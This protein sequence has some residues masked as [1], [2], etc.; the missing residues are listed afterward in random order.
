MRSRSEI[1]M[2]FADDKDEAEERR[3]FRKRLAEVTA[4]IKPWENRILGTTPPERDEKKAKKPDRW[5]LI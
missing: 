4:K 5:D 1:P 2:T 3:R